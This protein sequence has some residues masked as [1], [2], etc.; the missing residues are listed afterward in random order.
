[1]FTFLRHFGGVGS[2]RFP[3]TRDVQIF[4]ANEEKVLPEQRVV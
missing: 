3:E 1:M 2:G 4:G